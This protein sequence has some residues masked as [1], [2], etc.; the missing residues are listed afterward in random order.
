VDTFRIGARKG[1][2]VEVQIAPGDGA[3][4]DASFVVAAAGVRA[5]EREPLRAEDLVCFRDALRALDEGGSAE[6]EM[7]TEDRSLQVRVTRAANG[8][9]AEC[10]AMGGG[11]SLLKLVIP[12]DGVHLAELIWALDGTL[13]DAGL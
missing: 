12:I 4:F 11:G 9:R 13:R 5:A 7:R 3:L 10:V 8:F 1:D 2:H 6:A